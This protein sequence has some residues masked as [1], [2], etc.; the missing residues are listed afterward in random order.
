MSYYIYGPTNQD[1]FINEDLKFCIRLIGEQQVGRG[2]L[3]SKG[4]RYIKS[5]A[6]CSNLSIKKLYCSRINFFV[7]NDNLGTYA[8]N[9]HSL[10]TASILKVIIDYMNN[11]LSETQRNKLIDYFGKNIVDVDT[12]FKNQKFCL[13]YID[14][15]NYR[16]Q[17]G[18]ADNL[19]SQMAII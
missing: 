18:K 15:T 13:Q 3:D 6:N 19:L 11:S 12:I 17:G 9:F 2:S 16:N 1:R 14:R 5:Q 8:F 7:Q 4:R 10:T